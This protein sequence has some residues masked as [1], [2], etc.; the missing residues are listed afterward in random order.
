M[1]EQNY[2]NEKYFS[3]KELILSRINKIAPKALN[4]RYTRNLYKTILLLSIS[5]IFVLTGSFVIYQKNTNHK[6][7]ITNL[8][9]RV[10]QYKQTPE[11]IDAIKQ[12]LRYQ[13]NEK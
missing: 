2:D 11:R 12:T 7:Y 1:E 9:G 8:K 5:V 10:V 4:K 6:I 13:R 3:K